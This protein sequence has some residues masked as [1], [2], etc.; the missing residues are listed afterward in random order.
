VAPQFRCKCPSNATQADRPDTAGKGASVIAAALTLL[1]GML[2]PAAAAAKPTVLTESEMDEVTASG[3]GIEARAFAQASGDHVLAHTRSDA[4]VST[5]NARE[6]GIGFAEG[7]AFACCSRQSDVAVGSSVSTTGEIVLRKTYVVEFR[8][9]IVERENDVR[10]FAYGY[11]AGFLVARSAEDGPHPS[12]HV[13]RGAWD[14]LGRSIKGLID[15]SGIAARDGVVTGF[16]FAPVFAA[17]LRW[18]LFR[19]FLAATPGGSLPGI[20]RLRRN[21]ATFL[22]AN[23]SSG[24]P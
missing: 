24:F 21:P 16:E 23:S 11:A 8:G 20:A 13:A 2:L 22:Q 19:E 17:G 18:R 15:V 5:I 14:H 7:L 1:L 3:I 6:I 12:E 4:L 10:H 9:A